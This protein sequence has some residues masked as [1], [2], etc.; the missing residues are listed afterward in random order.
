MQPATF[1]FWTAL[2][3][4]AFA[5]S[6]GLIF[7]ENRGQASPEVQFIARSEGAAILFFEDGI[8]FPRES[9]ARLT[10]RFPGHDTASRWEPLDP[11]PSTSSYFL[12]NDPARWVRHASHSRRLIRRGIY[13]GIDLVFYANR[14]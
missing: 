4:P 14:G 13:R 5:L 10:L 11:M 6:H 8:S 12:G 9:P 2:L 3:C 7:E 1:L